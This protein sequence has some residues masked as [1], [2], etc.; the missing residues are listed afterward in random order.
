MGGVVVDVTG[1]AASAGLSS[2]CPTSSGRRFHGVVRQ[3]RAAK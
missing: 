2:W 3:V 1:A